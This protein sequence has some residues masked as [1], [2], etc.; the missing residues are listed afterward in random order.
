MILIVS[1]FAL[2][3][4]C[5]KGSI[6][7]GGDARFYARLILNRISSLFVVRHFEHACSLRLC[8][9]G[10][11]IEWCKSE[12]CFKIVSPS[13]MFCFSVRCRSDLAV[14]AGL[15]L[16][17]SFT[18]T[19][20]S[21]IPVTAWLSAKFSLP[22]FFFDGPLN[23]G[24]ESSLPVAQAQVQIGDCLALLTPR[25]KSRCLVNVRIT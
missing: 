5:Q 22:S 13:I 21:E 10:I 6:F 8:L 23:A 1:Y 11:S 24:S 17:H 19:V 3:L 4:R 18:S 14:V 16:R 2:L 20:G 15:R 9:R 25:A 12:K 7:Q